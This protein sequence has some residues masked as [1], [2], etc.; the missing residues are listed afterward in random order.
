MSTMNTG[1]Y[2]ALTLLAP[3]KPRLRKFALALATHSFLDAT[4]A[5]GWNN[6]KKIGTREFLRHSTRDLTRVSVFV[7]NVIVESKNGAEIQL[8]TKLKTV[9]FLNNLSKSLAV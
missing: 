1:R 7:L 5:F 8:S 2:H 9:V 4:Q 6:R 3:P